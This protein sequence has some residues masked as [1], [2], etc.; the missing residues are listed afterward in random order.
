ML[1]SGLHLGT[2]KYVYIYNEEILE[3]PSY[4]EQVFYEESLVIGA[5]LSKESE[6]HSP[7]W[8]DQV[9]HWICILLS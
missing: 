9:T 2:Q 6:G 7:F 1:Q 3:G 4:F 5:V 8:I